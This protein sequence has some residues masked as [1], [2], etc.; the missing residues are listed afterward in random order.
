MQL[1]SLSIYCIFP[2]AAPGQPGGARQ[3]AKPIKGTRIVPSSSSSFSLSSLELSDTKVREPEKRALL[4][5]ASQFCPVAG[6][7]RHL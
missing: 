7:S 2:K 5:T 3:K 4:G 1:Y 6:L